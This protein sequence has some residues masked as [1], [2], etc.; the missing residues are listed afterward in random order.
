MSHDRRFTDTDEFLAVHLPNL[1]PLKGWL[2]YLNEKLGWL[3]VNAQGNAVMRT[4]LSGGRDEWTEWNYREDNPQ[5][6][7]RNRN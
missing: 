3:K 7:K 6:H 2:K 1:V 4:S 5:R